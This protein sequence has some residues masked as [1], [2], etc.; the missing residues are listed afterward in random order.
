[1]KSYLI[2]DPKIYSSN[3][4]KFE[5]ILNKIINNNQIDYICFRDKDSSNY[6]E[7]ANSFVKISKENNIPNIFINSHIELAYSLN[8]T[9]V[10]LTSTQF[11]KIAYAKS[12]GLKTII[13]THNE[14]DIKQAIN[15][16]VDYIT[17][18][19]IFDTPNKGKA[20]GIDDLKYITN[21]Y[22]DIKIF[23][24]GGIV[25]NNH[26][27]MIKSINSYGF[28]SIRYFLK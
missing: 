10:H 18:S 9:G 1:M 26:I 20:K 7:L 24:L 12:I 6:E 4:N 2:T 11:D 16:N 8:A 13:S 3:L 17:Y 14:N 19:P 28:A 21:K 23:A 15:N 5:S 25:S 27:D 22:K